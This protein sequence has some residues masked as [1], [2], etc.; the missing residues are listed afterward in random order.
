MLDV[1]ELRM[2]QEETTNRL[3]TT[4]IQS[5]SFRLKS[6]YAINMSTQLIY[7]YGG[8]YAYIT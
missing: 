6:I 8:F 7:I 5:A 2:S 4:A 3:T 1:E